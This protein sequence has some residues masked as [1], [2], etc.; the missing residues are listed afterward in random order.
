MLNLSGMQDTLDISLGRDDNIIME[1]KRVKDYCKVY[2]IGADKREEIGIRTTI[3]NN[4]NVAIE[5]IVEDQIPVTT[6]NQIEVTLLSS[7]KAEH[8]EDTG[9]LKWVIK[10]KPGESKELNFSYSIR[11]PKDR[12][13]NL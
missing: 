12:K 8:N 11:F 6:N 3:T 9:K 1:R 7:K 5:M 2:A 4:K 13:I 10:L